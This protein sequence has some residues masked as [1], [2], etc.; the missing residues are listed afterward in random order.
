[1]VHC[2]ETSWFI[3]I[4]IWFQN[5]HKAISE[6]SGSVF[7]CIH[8][9]HWTLWTSGSFNHHCEQSWLFKVLQDRAF[10]IKPLWVRDGNSGS[11]SFYSAHQQV[12]SDLTPKQLLILLFLSLIIQSNLGQFW[13]V[14][15]HKF[16]FSVTI[17]VIP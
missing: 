10:H 15:V 5:N 14:Y 17:T 4:Q 1:M 12:W 8:F 2:G 3:Y 16:H 9:R 11:K 7:T 6:A 13:L